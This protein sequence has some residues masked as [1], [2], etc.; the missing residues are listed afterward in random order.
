MTK[1]VT[2]PVFFRIFDRVL[3]GGGCWD[4]PG[5][6]T[7]NG[8]GV[9]GRGR[10]GEGNALVHRAVYEEMVGPI[11]NGLHLDHLCR[12]R[13]CCRPDHLEAVTQAENNRRQAG[14]RTTCPAG[15]PYDGQTN[16][17]RR[18]LTCHRDRERS[19]RAAAC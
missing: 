17:S 11:P 3:V 19:R 1:H 10:R 8:Y 9:V 7:S 5:A 18:C 6:T 15:H 12:N 4:W 16:G 13:R 14:A 2:D